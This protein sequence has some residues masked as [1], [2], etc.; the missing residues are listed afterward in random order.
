MVRGNVKTKSFQNIIDIVPK[1]E[2]SYWNTISVQLNL[3][4]LLTHACPREVERFS[5]DLMSLTTI[6][7]K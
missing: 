2:S 1:I 4:V 3:K 7:T 6:A 5:P